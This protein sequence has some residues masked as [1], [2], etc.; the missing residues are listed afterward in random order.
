MQWTKQILI[1]I[2]IVIVVYVFT[3]PREHLCA[4]TPQLTANS[5]R[6]AC[7]EQRGVYDAATNTCSC[8]NGTV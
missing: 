6:K 2:A 7:E 1:L 5:I 4:L 3:R 8:A